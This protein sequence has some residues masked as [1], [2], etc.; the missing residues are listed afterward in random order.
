LCYARL[1]IYSRGIGGKG[2]ENLYNERKFSSSLI[3]NHN[4]KNQ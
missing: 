2:L 4:S 3:S 1:R